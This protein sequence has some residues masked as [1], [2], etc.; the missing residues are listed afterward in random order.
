MGRRPGRWPHAE[1]A[2]EQR[3]VRLETKVDPTIFCNSTVGSSLD[4]HIVRNHLYSPISETELL[5][6]FATSPHSRLPVYDETIDQKE[7]MVLEE[8]PE[9]DELSA[10]L[11][12]HELEILY[13]LAML[14]KM[15]DI[16]ERANHLEDLDKKFIPFARKLRKL[17]QSFEDEQILAMVSK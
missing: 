5:Q 11:P 10:V 9:N 8:L 13:E 16:R 17:A 4:I 1:T 6:Q 12:P 3:V 15:R 2:V 14:G 7:N